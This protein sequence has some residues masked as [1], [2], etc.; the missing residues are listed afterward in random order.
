LRA[1]WLDFKQL[2]KRKEL[3]ENGSAII[4]SKRAGCKNNVFQEEALILDID[5]ARELADTAPEIA[6]A[7]KA[8]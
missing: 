6:E 2:K 4:G 5:V 1:T 7:L 3:K 8:K